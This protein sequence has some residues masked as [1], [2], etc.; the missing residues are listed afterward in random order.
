M[1]GPGVVF[2][3]PFGDPA[4]SDPILILGRMSH[5]V[6]AHLVHLSAVHAVNANSFFRAWAATVDEPNVVLVADKELGGRQPQLHVLGKAI[7]LAR[8]KLLGVVGPD[9]ARWSEAMGIPVITRPKVVLDQAVVAER[10]RLR[11]SM[12]DKSIQVAAP[13]VAPT[14]P[15]PVVAVRAPSVQETAAP[16]ADTRAVAAIVQ[17]CLSAVDRG[18]DEPASTREVAA[19]VEANIETLDADGRPDIN[20]PVDVAVVDA[21]DA[22]GTTAA[23]LTAIEQ[24]LEQPMMSVVDETPEA[25]SQTEQLTLDFVQRPLAEDV[26]IQAPAWQQERAPE[27]TLFA[28]DA[29]LLAAIPA[30]GSDSTAVALPEE[31]HTDA[32]VVVQ[33]ETAEIACS[34]SGSDTAALVEAPNVPPSSEWTVAPVDIIERPIRSWDEEQ[35]SFEARQA[36]ETT[37]A[38][39]QRVVHGEPQMV[40]VQPAEP[41]R[42]KGRVRSGQLITNKGAIVVEGSV[43]SGGEL[44]AGGDIYV[45]GR[46]CGRLLAGWPDN[47]TACIYVDDFAAEFIAIGTKHHIFEHVPAH[48]RGKSIKISLE[49]DGSMNF[50]QLKERLVA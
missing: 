12:T 46:A 6:T 4:M 30:I 14:P 2:W 43:H 25:E 50:Q 39:T 35:D 9:A 22:D 3:P 26:P 41:V 36:T 24:A 20:A 45:Y 42:H 7:G 44:V 18:W 15:T 29:D 21:V 23:L 33:A 10:E 32:G 40:V 19:D 47:N 34:V 16:A 11:R 17:Q 28:V 48:W 49:A 31:A 5:P 1:T 27:D 8:V 13:Q 37:Q 38:P